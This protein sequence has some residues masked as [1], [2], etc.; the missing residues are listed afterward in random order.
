MKNNIRKELILKVAKERFAKYGFKKTTMNEIAADLKM[1]KPTLY[2]YFPTKEQIFEEV[3][4]F[5]IDEF[6]NALKEIE[7]NENLTIEGKLKLYFDV[8]LKTFSDQSNL[9]QLQIDA[10]SLM[11]ILDSESLYFKLIDIEIE[12]LRTI[13]LK[14]IPRSK[15][16][17]EEAERFANYLSTYARGILLMFRIDSRRANSFHNLP[18]NLKPENKWQF[19]VQSLTKNLLHQE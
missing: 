6:Q 16:K 11:H 12:F 7:K 1:G 15:N 8:R 9:Y 10:V 14:A 5:E 2:Y 19:I 18:E 17:E 3:L 4:K 13:L